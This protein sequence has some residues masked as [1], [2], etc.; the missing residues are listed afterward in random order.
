VTLMESMC[1]TRFGS[2]SP[3]FKNF[4]NLIILEQMAKHDTGRYLQK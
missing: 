1:W 2:I 3:G 4:C